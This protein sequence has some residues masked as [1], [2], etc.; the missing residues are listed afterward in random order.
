MRLSNES[1][2]ETI[3]W[4]KAGISLPLFNRDEMI[5]STRAAPKWVH[6]GAGNI[7]RAFPACLAQSLLEQ[8]LETTGVVVAVRYDKETIEKCFNRFD[9]L[10]LLVTLKSDGS[11]DKK[12]I[13]SIASY[14][15]MDCD[16]PALK[17]IFINPS[18]QMATFTITEKGYNLT[19]RDGAFLP[20]IEEDLNAGPAASKSFLGRIAALCHERYTS[21]AHPLALVSMDNCSHN[22]DRLFAAAETFAKSWIQKGQ[23]DSGFLDYVRD[24]KKLSFPWTMIDKITPGPDK[25]IEETLAALGLEGMRSITAGKNTL[26]APFVNA[27]ETQYLVIEDAFPNGRPVLEKAGVLFTDRET[28]DKVEKMKVGAC[29]NPIHTAL[30]V[31]G[32]LLGYKR[33]NEEMNDPDLVKLAEGIGY[34]EGLPVAVDPE[35]INPKQFLDEVIKVR[36]PNPFLP[37]A[38]QR[39]A[40][41]SSQKIPVRFGGTLKAYRDSGKNLKELKLIPLV[42]AGWLRYLLGVDDQGNPFAVS[43]DPLYESLKAGLSGITMGRIE[44]A[45][46]HSKLEPILSRASLFGLNLYEAG[47]GEKAE[48]YFTQMIAGPGAVRKLLSQTVS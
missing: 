7:F 9:N 13:A 26:I 35:I 34:L 41:D 36:L 14:L 11:T 48:D 23:T 2:K 46:I 43:P 15:G 17:D 20:E 37:D 30:A 40:A 45:F 1:L 27:E 6:F 19:G 32:C 8:G 25:G 38:P 5:S 21:G 31:F 22:G 24:P 39:I 4:K 47:L 3:F 16:S 33:I 18:L 10:T 28:V 12:V 44:S 42:F 29:L